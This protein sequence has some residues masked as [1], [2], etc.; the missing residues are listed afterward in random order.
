MGTFDLFS[1]RK[2]RASGEIVDVFDYDKIPTALRVQIVH[3]WDQAIGNANQYGDHYG[4][5]DTKGAYQILV[6]TLRREYGVFRLTDRSRNENYREELIDFLLTTEDTDYALDVIEISFRMIDRV[7]RDWSRSFSRAAADVIEELN[8]RFLEHG[9]GY[10]Y[11]DGVIIK[12]D[13]ELTHQEII[14][15]AL[16]FLSEERFAG[17]REE[18]LSAFEHYRKGKHKEALNDCLKS[19]E[20]TM[21][22]ICSDRGWNYNPNSNSKQLIQTLFDNGL[23]PAFWQSQL[24][25][26]RTILESSVPTGRNKLSGHGQGSTPQSVPKSIVQYMIHMTGS[27]IVFLATAD[28]ELP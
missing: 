2:K 15:P 10:C 8:T 4:D 20:S 28:N 27:V 23:V 9:I 14:K 18:F 21:K 13:T 16:H 1:K 24:S 5:G 12:K 26:L 17:A 19:F 25:S 3:M 7:C 22:S 6:Q 11:E